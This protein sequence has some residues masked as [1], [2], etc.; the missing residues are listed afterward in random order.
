MDVVTADGVPRHVTPDGEPDL[1]WALLG[2]R[3]NVGIVTGMEFGLVA[4]SGL[5]GGGLFFDAEQTPGLLDAYRRWTATAP[6]EMNSSVALLP[7]PDDPQ[8]PAPSSC[9][10]CS[11]R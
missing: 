4:V 1:Y 11:T 2:G 9:S 8:V 6:V 10:R 5:Y 3:D 7:F